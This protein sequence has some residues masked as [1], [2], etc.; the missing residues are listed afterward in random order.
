MTKQL[1]SLPPFEKNDLINFIIWLNLQLYT[2][3]EIPEVY[4]AM[5]KAA[6]PA[7]GVIGFYKILH[8]SVIKMDSVI[9]GACGIEEVQNAS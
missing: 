4:Q 6:V 9:S 2:S 1:I 7:V 8:G 5:I 3:D